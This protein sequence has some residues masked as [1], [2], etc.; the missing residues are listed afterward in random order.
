MVIG[1]TKELEQLRQFVASDRPELIAV[2]G[3][4][5]VGKTYMISET[6][7]DALA[8]DM[9]GVLGGTLKTELSAWD[10]A[11]RR[12][13]YNKTEKA[14]NWFDA[15]A[16]LEDLM[17]TKFRPHERH[18]LFIDELPC[19]DTP[20]SEFLP[21][22]DHFWNSWASR[23]SGLKLIVCGSAAS[24]IVT[25]LINSHGG[26]H[27]RITHEMHIRPFTLSETEKYLKSQGFSWSRLMIAQT[28]MVFG[29]I[30]YYLSLLSKSESL[31]QNIDRLFFQDGELADEYERLYR[32]L[33]KNANIYMNVIK[34]LANAKSGLTRQE[35]Q[36]KLKLGDGGNLTAVLRNLEYSDFISC[37]FVRK[38]KEISR[39]GIYRLVDFFT[40][41]YY[42]FGVKAVSD[43]HFWSKNLNTPIVNTWQGLAFE[44][45]CLAHVEQ[46][47]SALGLASIYAEHYSWR[48]LDGETGAQIDMIV[49][50]ADGIVNLCEI[51]FSTT[52]YHLN[53]VE[54]MKILTR[55]SVFQSETNIGK[56]VQITMISP[57][58]VLAGQYASEISS[59]VTLAELYC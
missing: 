57:I 16:A 40:Q 7:S 48:S 21:A 25:N 37:S 52:P 6:F 38:K 28:Y 54:Y 15:F 9:T 51:K 50:R 44:R 14:T 5:R 11:M 49:D 8:F 27:N 47:K 20:K 1:R 46:I 26:L 33:F 58:G 3:R 34:A 10:R 19:L 4:R 55:Q 12:S 59:V 43:R 18:I 24:W 42:S 22:F 36:K 17:E 23:R 56:G 29:G 30:P 39:S 35:L 32:S 13:G 41:F 2:Y 53:K 31:S 45:L